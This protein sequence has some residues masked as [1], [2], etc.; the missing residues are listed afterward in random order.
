MVFLVGLYLLLTTFALK[1]VVADIGIPE[2][3][4]GLEVPMTAKHPGIAIGNATAGKPALETGIGK[5]GEVC[6]K[7]LEVGID[8]T[9]I[10]LSAMAVDAEEMAGKTVTEPIAH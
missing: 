2:A 1:T 10:E 6:S 5:A 7:E 9:D 4:F 3:D 8:V